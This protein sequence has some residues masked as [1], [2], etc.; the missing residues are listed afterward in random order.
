[1]AR[2]LV[3]EDD[4]NSL[5]LIAYLL[6]AF[7][8]TPITA[9]DGEEGLAKALNYQPDLI[10]CDVQIP[11]VHGFEVV[12]QLK[13][14]PTF[15]QVPIIAVTAFAMVGD[16]DKVLAAGFDSYIAKP[17]A[18][19]NFIDQVESFLISPNQQSR[20]PE[21]TSPMTTTMPTDRNVSI[22]ALDNSPTNL[23]FL[24]SLLQLSGYQV[25]A[26]ATIHQAIT[27]ATQNPPQLIISDLHLNGE[28]G[29]DFIAQVKAQPR[30]ASIP[31]IFLTS[32]AWERSD[33]E[34]GMNAGAMKYLVRPID[35]EVLL[36]EVEACLRSVSS[37]IDPEDRNR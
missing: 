20:R 7:G 1:M 9:V 33:R 27:L 13:H 11:K 10:L 22:L 32:T 35:P 6:N 31:F 37:T 34:K 18:P 25:I 23:E 12:R 15:P 24:Q 17:I 2:I 4:P 26:A 29:F 21:A 14:D 30:L 16:R 19:E 28:S 3:I 36:A 5:E 8:H